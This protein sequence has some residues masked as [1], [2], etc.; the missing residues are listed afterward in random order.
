MAPKYP[1]KSL[2]FLF[3]L[4]ALVSPTL[5]ECM[6]FQESIEAKP[7]LAVGEERIPQLYETYEDVCPDFV[8][9]K[10]C[11]NEHARKLMYINFVK[12]AVPFPCQSC[13][14]NMRRFLLNNQLRLDL[15]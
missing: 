9:K 1:P 2:Q 10:V 7:R 8:G 3:L 14:N 4:A 5:E 12:L 11:C 6:I 13:A 15:L